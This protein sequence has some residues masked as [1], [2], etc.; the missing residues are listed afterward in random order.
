VTD[1]PNDRTALSAPCGA[2]SIGTSVGTNAAPNPVSAPLDEADL[3]TTGDMARLSN[4]TLRT[5][6]FYEEEGLIT[7]V[8]RGD[9]EHRKFPNCELKKLQTIA[10]LREAGL[11]LQEI[12]ALIALKKHCQTPNE[13]SCQLSEALNARVTEIETRIATLQRT[14]E[15]LLR[16]VQIL[17]NCRNCTEPTFPS[18]CGDCDRVK[19]AE[20]GAVRLLWKN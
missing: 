13:A 2:A 18:G 10:E 8:A 12:K 20:P 5:V 1:K 17:E 4:T 9:G 3:L 19:G 6:R 16:A 15:E 14:R 11:S 7:P